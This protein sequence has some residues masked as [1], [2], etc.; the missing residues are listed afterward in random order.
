MSK[1]SDQHNQAVNRLIE[2]ANELKD[3]GFDPRVI[4]AALLSAAGIY[5]TFVEAGNDGFLQSEGVDKLTEIFRQQLIHIQNLKK[6]ELRQAGHKVDKPSP[7]PHKKADT[8][9]AG[10]K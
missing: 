1:P 4:S 9:K 6:E 7:R 2:S 10:A 3:K 8:K 5:T